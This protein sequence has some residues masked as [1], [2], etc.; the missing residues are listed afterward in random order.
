MNP[1]KSKNLKSKVG[2]RKAGSRNTSFK[3]K[4]KQLELTLIRTYPRQAVWEVWLPGLP[5]KLTTTVTTG[6]IA[7]SLPLSITSITAFATRFSQ[8]FVEYRIIRA[9]WRIRFFS[10]TNPGVIQFWIDEKSAAAPVL[11]EAQ[12]RYTL[13]CS[14]SSVDTSPVLKWICSDP[15]DLQYLATS[16]TVVVAS[17]KSF[18]NNTNFGS[19]I[20]AT[21]YCEIE[22]E[23]QVQ[24]RGL[25]GV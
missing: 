20:V 22:P 4:E 15:L 1:Q 16:A 12:E 5:V 8:T 14:A 17:F 13:T 18:T 11:A 9:H 21:D 7:S 24:F 25:Q 6:A 10:S 23:F 3:Q 19:S 2:N